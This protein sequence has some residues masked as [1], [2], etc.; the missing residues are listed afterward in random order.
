MGASLPEG[1]YRELRCDE[2]PAFRDHLLRLDVESRR[3]RFC[4]SVN[5]AFIE[6][7][8]ARS[9]SA[10]GPTFGYFVGDDL[11]AAAELRASGARDSWGPI[12]EGA[13]SVESA[14]QGA[15]I[16]TRLVELVVAAARQREVTHLYV[17]CLPEN[18]RMQRIATRFDARL[19]YES[20]DVVADID[21]SHFDAPFIQ[22]APTP[23]ALKL[24]D[25]V[26]NAARADAN[27]ESADRPS[28]ERPSA[29]GPGNEVDARGSAPATPTMFAPMGQPTRVISA[30]PRRAARVRS[31][32]QPGSAWAPGLGEAEL[33]SRP[34]SSWRHWLQSAMGGLGGLGGMRH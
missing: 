7:Y 4:H 15:G 11:R 28:A 24:S 1:V 27:S 33:T 5:D 32:V 3:M 29:H 19:V 2:V 8:A 16:G 25:D 20:G 30:H 34:R 18:E 22:L 6:S 21:P 23:P 31:G 14:Y 10:N 26:E 17:S 12:A 13:F 9:L